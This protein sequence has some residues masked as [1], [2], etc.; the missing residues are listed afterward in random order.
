ML[1]N[2]CLWFGSANFEIACSETD[3]SICTTRCQTL[4]V[5]IR[6]NFRIFHIQCDAITLKLFPWNQ[7]YSNFF[8]QIDDLTKNVDFFHKNRDRDLKRK[9]FSIKACRVFVTENFFSE[10][11]NFSFLHL[12]MFEHDFLFGRIMLKIL[13]SGSTKWNIYTKNVKLMKVQT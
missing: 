12:V 4:Y 10:R 1:N 5:C 8:G 7:F 13:P 11:V 6:I 9:Y 2:F 3:E